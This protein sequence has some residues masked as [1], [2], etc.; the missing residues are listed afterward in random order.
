MDTINAFAL[1]LVDTENKIKEK[2]QQDAAFHA[3]DCV[4]QLSNDVRPLQRS[5]S[6]I[7]TRVKRKPRVDPL[8]V[9]SN[10]CSFLSDGDVYVCRYNGRVHVC[11]EH[12]QS[13][14]LETSGYIC[15]LTG[16]Y[17]DVAMYDQK[18]SIQSYNRAKS[19]A[20]FIAVCGKVPERDHEGIWQQR[21]SHVRGIIMKVVGSD[22]KCNKEN[23]LKLSNE[24]KVYLNFAL[25]K[26]YSDQKH[27]ELFLSQR[28][29]YFQE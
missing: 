6:N 7:Q 10:T 16:R 23:T 24:Q 12:C 14:V 13:M 25:A 3:F 21:F 9:C 22:A 19:D 17:V 1:D 29:V 27:F 4:T 5:L 15:T 8:H 11:G 28:F 26:S 18:L 2:I 20:P